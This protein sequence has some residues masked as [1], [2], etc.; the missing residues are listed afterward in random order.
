MEIPEY[1]K[2]EMWKKTLNEISRSANLCFSIISTFL[3]SWDENCQMVD[4]AK[5]IYYGEPGVVIVNL[6]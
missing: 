5:L 2:S 1:C 3:P 6:F 4:E